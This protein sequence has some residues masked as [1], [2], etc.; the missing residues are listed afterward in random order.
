MIFD[1]YPL[2]KYAINFFKYSFSKSNFF[3]RSVSSAHWEEMI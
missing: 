2:I 3:F 1:F